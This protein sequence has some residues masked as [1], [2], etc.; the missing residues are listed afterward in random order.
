MSGPL[1]D[2]RAAPSALKPGDRVDRWRVLE[3][4][5]SG[6]YGAVYLVDDVDAPGRTYAL[7]LALRPSDTRAEREV[8]LPARTEHS[9]VVHI[10]A[11]AEEEC[12]R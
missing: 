8:A 1:E 3:R 7:K 12:S 10:R 4:L 6:S 5:G 2:G 9:H 11:G